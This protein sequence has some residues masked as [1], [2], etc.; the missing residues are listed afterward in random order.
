[1][2]NSYFVDACMV[3]V[4]NYGLNIL[5]EKRL[6]IITQPL[7]LFIRMDRN[8]NAFRSR[9]PL[10]VEQS[11]KAK[12]FNSPMLENKIN[13]YVRKSFS[14]TFFCSHIYV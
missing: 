13:D 10:A 2:Y 9:K 6:Y 8:E 4:S 14:T 3:L 12:D 7:F 11:V 1:M 5:N